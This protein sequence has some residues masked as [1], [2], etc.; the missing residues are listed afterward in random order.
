M[1]RPSAIVLAFITLAAVVMLVIASIVI[2]NAIQS[3]ND[4][5][6]AGLP[7]CS[8]SK[9]SASESRMKIDMTGAGHFTG[10]Y[11]L[12][13]K[14]QPKENKIVFKMAGRAE[15]G[16]MSGSLTSEGV[17][18]GNLAGTYS[19][20]TI[21]FVDPQDPDVQLHFTKAPCDSIT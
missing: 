5:S 19:R 20:T 15:N 17:E 6:E 11:I 21:D 2:T 9:T 13:L 18:F 4:T 10:T 16:K 12:R 8:I 14:D 3:D 7:L 1:K